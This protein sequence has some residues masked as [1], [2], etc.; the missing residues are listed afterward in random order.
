MRIEV[1]HHFHTDVDDTLLQEFRAFVKHFD[2]RINKIDAD[3][4]EVLGRIDTATNNIA[5]DLR[6]LKEQISTGMT[7]QQ[8]AA[9]K[10]QFEQRATVLEAIAADTEDP[11]P[12]T[13]PTEPPTE[14]TP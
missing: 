8:V 2:Q 1:H 14:P 9:L 4:T 13:P 3:F 7:P 5:E 11:V 6:R 12:E 10:A